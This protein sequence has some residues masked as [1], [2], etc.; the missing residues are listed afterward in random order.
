MSGTSSE[1]QYLNNILYE[2]AVACGIEVSTE[3]SKILLNSTTNISAINDEKLEEVT[4]FKYL[5]ATLP[6]VPNKNYQGDRS[7]GQTEQVVD[8]QFDQLLQQ[9]QDQ[10]VPRSLHPTVRLRGLGTLHAD[11]CWAPRAPTG[12]RQTTKAFF[13]STPH[14]GR[15]SVQDCS[16][17]FA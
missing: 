17:K 4:S 14:Q 3:K 12:D 9:A 11:T 13:V 16:P 2:R 10:Q 7:N 6:K 1:I 15:L 8:E 5:G